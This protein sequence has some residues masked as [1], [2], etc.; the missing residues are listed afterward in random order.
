MECSR[1]RAHARDLGNNG[2]SSDGDLDLDHSDVLIVG[3]S[4]IGIFRPIGN[5]YVGVDRGKHRLA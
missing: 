1:D 4:V 3:E 5:T 2:I